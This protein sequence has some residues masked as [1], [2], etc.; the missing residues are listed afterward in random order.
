[1]LSKKTENAHTL[2]PLPRAWIAQ[3]GLATKCRSFIV[4][5][6]IPPSPNGSNGGVS[7]ETVQTVK[8]IG[9][10]ANGGRP[11]ETAQ[12]VE[13]I[14]N[15]NRQKAGCG[16]VGFVW[17]TSQYPELIGT[18]STASLG[19]VPSPV[20]TR[21]GIG[22]TWICEVKSCLSPVV[23]LGIGAGHGRSHGGAGAR[24]VLAARTRRPSKGR[25]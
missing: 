9:N 22:S 7:I 6:T 15:G 23:C 18:A 2:C 17:L 8:P 16:R 25:G 5:I 24:L 1:M 3:S 14:G 13:P 12:T 11:I 10:G 4:F 20:K 21:L 19:K